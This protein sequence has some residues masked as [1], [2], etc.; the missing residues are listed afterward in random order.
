MKTRAV[1]DAPYL[2]Y[3][4]KAH[5]TNQ[6]LTIAFTS[7]IQIVVPIGWLGEPWTTATK[8]QL[9]NV[10]LQS[11]GSTLWWEDLDE[12]FVLD[13]ILPG[14]FG[15]KPAVLLARLGRGRS[16]PKKAA[17]ARA[18]GRRGGRPPKKAA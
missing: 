5:V 7:T 13:E 16:T 12:G 8:Q 9:R 4:E 14:M 18:N 6:R 1:I 11:G 2:I 17:A 15:I 3:A 10:R